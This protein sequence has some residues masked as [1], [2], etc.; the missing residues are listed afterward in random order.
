MLH[1]VR[2]VASYMEY[3]INTYDVYWCRDKMAGAFAGVLRFENDR[4]GD[5]LLLLMYCY[6]LCIVITYLLLLHVYCYYLCIVITCV[7]LLL[8]YCYYLRYAFVSVSYRHTKTYILRKFNFGRT[9]AEVPHL[10]HTRPPGG[11]HCP[12]IECYKV[13]AR[14]N[15]FRFVLRL[16]KENMIS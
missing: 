16:A 5:A 13:K 15:H 4:C 10:Q 2:D 11:Q 3:K 12:C 6:Y 9:H 8:M 14:R 7:L 1:R